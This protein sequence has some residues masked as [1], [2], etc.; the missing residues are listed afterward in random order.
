MKPLCPEWIST[1]SANFMKAPPTFPRY[2][3]PRDLK[4][5][6][7]T[8]SNTNPPTPSPHCPVFHYLGKNITMLQK[9]YITLGKLKQ[10]FLWVLHKLLW[11]QLMLE[12]T[13]VFCCCFFVNDI[14]SFLKILC[15]MLSL[16][17]GI[18]PLVQWKSFWALHLKR[19][20]LF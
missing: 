15:N 4:C 12:T 14:K 19:R 6:H 5:C 7:Q 11:A 13:W 16:N 8:F 17:T 9:I 20:T 2:F 10:S 3:H 1:N 18:M